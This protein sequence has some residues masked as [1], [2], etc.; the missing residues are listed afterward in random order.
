MADVPKLERLVNLTAV[1][2]DARRPLSRREITDAVPGYE[3]NEDAV[4]KSFE[5]DKALLRD[6]GIPVETEL[7]NPAYPED[8]EGYRIRR[9]DYA[10]PDPGLDPEELAALN[11]AAATVRLEGGPATEAIW[12]LGGAVA[13]DRDL[14]TVADLPGH[15]YLPLFFQ[16]VAERRVVTF[17]YKG[18]A[19][20]VRPHRVQFQFGRWYLIGDEGDGGEEVSKSFRLDRVE[21]APTTGAANAFSR[22]EETD[23]DPLAEPP[24]RMG[25]EEPVEIDVLVDASQAELAERQARPDPVVERRGDGSIVIRLRVT[26]TDGYRAF[27][28]DL[29]DCAEVLGPPEARAAFVQWLEA[30]T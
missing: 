17:T 10:M 24:W 18:T 11:L 1:L 23:H 16:A 9:E 25:D 21:G 3:G 22:P 12:K 14:A 28:T 26:N 29:L 19:R 15:E 13:F 30:I 2:L 6:M 7:V 8:G 4:R 27:V 20:R 5:R